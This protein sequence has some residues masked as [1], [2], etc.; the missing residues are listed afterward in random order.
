MK[1]VNLAFC[2]IKLLFIRDIHAKFG[3]HNSSQSSDMAQNSD[4]GIPI[5]EFLVK[6][7]MNKYRH[8]TRASNDID[9]KLEPVNKL[10]KRNTTTF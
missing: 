6:F 2:S 8:N 5:S 9:M 7:F 4:E 10:N 3:I 1:A